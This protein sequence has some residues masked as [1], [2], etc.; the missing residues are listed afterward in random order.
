ML[1]RSTFVILGAIL[2]GSLGCVDAEQ[3]QEAFAPTGYERARWRVDPSSLN[4]VAFLLRRIVISHRE[5][6]PEQTTEFWPFGPHSRTRAEALELATQIAD[7]VAR[8]KTTFASLAQLHSDDH[9][10]SPWGGITGVVRA[11]MLAEEVIDALAQVKEGETSLPIDTPVGYQV[12]L[13]EPIPTNNWI[14]VEAINIRYAGAEGWCRVGRACARTREEARII[15]DQVSRIV[16]R[17]PDA[18]LATAEKVDESFSSNGTADLGVRSTHSADSDALLWHLVAQAP[19]NVP[20]GVIETPRGFFIARRIASK[21]RQL[22]AHSEIVVTH[23]AGGLESARSRSEAKEIAG[24][25]LREALQH[26]TR[27]DILRQQN[28]DLHLCEITLPPWM[29]GN[30]LKSFESVLAVLKHGE[31]AR[32]LIETPIGFHI[33]RREAPQSLQQDEEKLSFEVPHP[34]FRDYYYFLR[35][36][37]GQSLSEM[38]LENAKKFADIQG[39]DK[40]TRKRFM[41]EIAAY[42]ERVREGSPSWDQRKQDYAAHLQRLDAVLGPQQLSSY[43]NFVD[44]RMIAMQQW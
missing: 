16:K 34:P 3:K 2:C 44:Q 13:R 23:S 38:T 6:R 11:T 20:I 15:A 7:A 24:R 10:T 39:L 25:V 30:H 41:G 22:F 9:V 42:G 43:L 40:E 17:V 8:D 37:D 14:D 12:V 19:E 29:E 32:V 33:V 5:I 31:I 4:R 36:L 35:T 26:P 27:F 18:F 1:S 28:C 21:S